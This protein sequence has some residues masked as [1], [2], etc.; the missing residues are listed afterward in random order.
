MR[1]PHTYIS[2]TNAMHTPQAHAPHLNY[3][4]Y[5]TYISILNQHNII[6]YHDRHICNIPLTWTLAWIAI[7]IWD[8][9]PSYMN[10]ESTNLFWKA[11]AMLFLVSRSKLRMDRFISPLSQPLHLPTQ[12]KMRIHT[13][14]TNTIVLI[15]DPKFFIDWIFI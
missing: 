15:S 8:T 1:I 6:C 3:I 12:N 7:T 4:S 14:N 2:S 5:A 13:P 10:S 9:H 11:R